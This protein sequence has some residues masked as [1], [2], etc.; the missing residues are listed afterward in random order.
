MT[1][2]VTEAPDIRVSESKGADKQLW[3]VAAG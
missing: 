2:A 1:G 3:S